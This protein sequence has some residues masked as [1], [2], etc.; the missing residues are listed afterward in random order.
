MAY[1]F[2]SVDRYARTRLRRACRH[3]PTGPRAASVGGRCS[4]PAGLPT[5]PQAKAVRTRYACGSWVRLCGQQPMTNK[6]LADR[7]GQPTRYDPVPRPAAG[8]G[9]IAGAG[10]DPHRGQRGSEK[11]L[12][13]LR[14][15]LV[16]VGLRRHRRGRALRR[17]RRRAPSPSIE[18]FQAELGE[19]GPGSV[20]TYARFM[21]HLSDEEVQELDR[22]LLAVLDE[23][24]QTDHQRLDRPAFAHVV[25]HQPADPALLQPSQPHLHPLP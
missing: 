10:T 22:R 19:A 7:V 5:I 3:D 8:Q 1:R 12:Q 9:R 25:L 16:A 2:R 17:P 14:A 11:L 23:Y 20:R 15:V 4:P 24:I 13:R 21:L 6:Q 18:A